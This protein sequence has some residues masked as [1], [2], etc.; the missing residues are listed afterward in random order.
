[1]RW[2]VL[3]IEEVDEVEDESTCRQIN[4]FKSDSDEIGITSESEFLRTKPFHNYEPL[5]EL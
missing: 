5:L 4:L 1:M 3:G 2:S